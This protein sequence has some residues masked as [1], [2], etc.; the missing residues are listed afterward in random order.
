MTDVTTHEPGTFCWVE[1]ATTDTKA[2]TGFYGKVFGWEPRT[3]PM[4]EEG[5]YTTFDLPGGRSAAGGYVQPDAEREQ[6][7]PPHWNLYVYTDDV[8]KTTA[9]AAELGANVIVPGLDLGMGRM[10]TFADPTG[11]V[12]SVW[13]SNQNPGFMAK[14]EHGSFSWPELL[15]PDKDR[16]EAFYTELFGWGTESTGE[17]MGNYTLLKRGE[18]SIGGVANPPREGI[19]PVWMV[20][21]EVDDADAA[22]RA[23]RDG[24]GRVEMEPMDIPGVGR[25]AVLA[26]PQGA[27][28]AVIK[29]E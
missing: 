16:A 17:E 28:F 18:A 24:G 3:M 9:R 15:T 8:D 4:P 6:G 27:T 2:A 10:G 5:E 25:F 20:Y 21:F 13:Q 29:S 19:P 11:A 22:V 12:I 7:I 1:L 23:T 14:D 26:D